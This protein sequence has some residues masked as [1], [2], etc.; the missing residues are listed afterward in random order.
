MGGEREGDLAGEVQGR[1][2]SRMWTRRVRVRL[3]T[4]EEDQGSFGSFFLGGGVALDRGF[5]GQG[6]DLRARCKG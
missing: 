6:S 5:G 3:N 2:S 1:N 4:K